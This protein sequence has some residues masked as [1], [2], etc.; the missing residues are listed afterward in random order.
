MNCRK[1]TAE[2][3]S[4]HRKF[5]QL[6]IWRNSAAFC[7]CMT[8]GLFSGSAATAPA[9]DLQVNFEHDDIPLPAGSITGTVTNTSTRHYR[10]IDLVFF[11]LYSGGMSGPAELRIN[12][13][14]LSPGAVS[15]YSGA[16]QTL[17]SFGLRR[18]EICSVS[19]ETEPIPDRDT[20]TI[21]GSVVSK[22]GFEGIDDRGQ[23]EKIKRI[24]LVTPAG[25]LIS[26]IGF[27]SDT[28]STTRY[29]I[30]TRVPANYSYNVQLGYEWK[31][32]PSRVPVDC[33]NSRG[34]FEFSIEP[35]KHTGN[36]LG[37]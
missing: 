31:T 4:P 32:D 11:L 10:C 33:P 20:C 25:K 22:T 5:Q 19:S 7:L 24:N 14:N 37:G 1:K 28:P 12:L 13:Q 26:E 16:L 17:A 21:T 15:A 8:V 18:I 6:K 34:E 23:S 27:R 36:R 9:D 35:L 29:F 3:D 30:F 2:F